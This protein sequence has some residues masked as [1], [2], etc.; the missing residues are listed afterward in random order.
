MDVALETLAVTAQLAPVVGITATTSGQGYFE[1]AAE[2]GL[3]AFGDATFQGSMG[4]K[5][6]NRPIVGTATDRYWEVAS[7]GGLFA[8]GAPFAGSTGGQVLNAPVVGMAA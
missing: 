1:V 3:F 8:L 4:G 6:L 2:G 7:D 5:H